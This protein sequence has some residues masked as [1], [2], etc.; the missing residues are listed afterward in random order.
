MEQ[1]EK[2]MQLIA[3]LSGE[4]GA[5]HIFIECDSEKVEHSCEKKNNE[6]IVFDLYEVE[7][8]KEG[9][10]KTA[11]ADFCEYCNQVFVYKTKE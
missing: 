11:I 9:K 4:L 6:R 7:F 3:L 10:V 2:D 5:E 8:F 1:H